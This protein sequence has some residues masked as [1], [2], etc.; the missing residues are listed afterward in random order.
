MYVQTQEQV[1]LVLQITIIKLA[2]ALGHLIVPDQGQL[3]VPFYICTAHN[4]TGQGGGWGRGRGQQA[5][6]SP[7]ANMS[8][9]LW[10]DL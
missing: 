1:L 3:G 5:N 9:W 4:W 7:E 6:A 2:R 8:P 10:L